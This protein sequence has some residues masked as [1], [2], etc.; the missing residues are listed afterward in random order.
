MHP[1]ENIRFEVRSETG[2]AIL[3]LNRP[4]ALNA[5]TLGLM[6]DVS[7]ALARVE[8]DP[9]IRALVLTGAGRGFCAGQDLKSRLPEGVDMVETLMGSYYKAFAAIRSS[10][11]PVIVAI[12]GVAAG[13]GCSLAL[14]GDLPIAAHSASL[15][16]VFSRIGLAPDLGSTWMLPRTIGRARALKMM[17]TG[18]A[19]SAPEA[20]EWGL[21]TDCV[22]DTEL[23]PSAMKLA[24]RLAAGPTLAYAATRKLV[25]EAAG[26]AFGKQCRLE[27]EANAWL[28][29]T[30]DSKEAVAAFVEKRKA[31]FTGG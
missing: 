8:A 22:A 30:S 4:E 5:L 12:N 24:T 20:L 14:A 11:V 2:V 6:N 15:I 9:E 17:M 27:L 23:M 29:D 26:N 16:Q 1:F 19:L 28:R 7:D 21:V 18:D 25:D 3:T 10:R 13:A 31:V